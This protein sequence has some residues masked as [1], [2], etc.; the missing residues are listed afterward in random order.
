MGEGDEAGF[1][2]G[3]GEIDPRGEHPLEETGKAFRVAPGSRCEVG[4]L[5]RGEEQGEHRTDAVD[6][7]GKAFSGEERPVSVAE[8]HGQSFQIR[9]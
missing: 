3:G 9:V 1:E 5:I 4:H 6:P 8:L 2:L 7:D